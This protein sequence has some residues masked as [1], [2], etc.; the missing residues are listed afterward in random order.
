M[1]MNILCP[2]AGYGGPRKTP[3]ELQNIGLPV[4][5]SNFI[6]KVYNKTNIKYS[7]FVEL[8]LV[9]IVLD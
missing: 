1:C 4:E 2:A 9:E 5:V 6:L 3:K 8:T 7:L